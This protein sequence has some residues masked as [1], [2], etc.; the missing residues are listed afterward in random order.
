LGLPITRSVIYK[1]GHNIYPKGY[2]IVEISSE[3]NKLYIAAFSTVN[4]ESFLLH[5]KDQDAESTLQKFGNDFNVLAMC[6]KFK[7]DRLILRNPK[8]IFK[9]HSLVL[10]Q[11]YDSS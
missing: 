5:L 7:N 6:L 8:N 2:F 10:D 11:N 3:M 4:H 1:K 9:Q